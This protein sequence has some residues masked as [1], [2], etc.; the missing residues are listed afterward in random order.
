MS[1]DIICEG[2]EEVVPVLTE[3]GPRSRKYRVRAEKEGLCYFTAEAEY[4]PSGSRM[5]SV[6]SGYGKGG[7][8]CGS[9]REAA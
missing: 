9:E 6:H 1:S 5:G 4:G 8:G 2:P 3:S 7:P